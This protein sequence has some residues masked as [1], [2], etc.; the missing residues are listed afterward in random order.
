MIAFDY[1]GLRLKWALTCLVFYALPFLLISYGL[2]ARWNIQEEESIERAF[3]GLDAVLLALRKRED[4]GEYIQNQIM[5]LANQAGK[6]SDPFGILRRGFRELK[7]RFPGVLRVTICDGEGK[8][9]SEMTDGNPPRMVVRRFFETVTSGTIH[10]EVRERFASKVGLFKSFIGNEISPDHIDAMRQG[11]RRCSFYET[12]RYFLYDCR[13]GRFG[14]LVHATEVP[15]WGVLGMQDQ[16]RRF[17]TL[18]SGFGVEVGLHDIATR[19]TV[20]GP[21]AIALGAYQRTN[22]QH[23]QAADQLFTVMPFLTTARLWARRPRADALDLSRTRQAFTFAGIAVFALLTIFSHSVMVG[24]RPFPIS[25]RWRLVVLFGFASGLPLAVV[26]LAGWDYLN[27]KY[28]TRVRQSHD[29]MERLLL[30]FDARFP[31]MRGKLEVT[32]VRELKACR[33]DTEAQMR[34]TVRVL[35][36]FR[37]RFLA[38]DLI[39]YDSRGGVSWDAEKKTSIKGDRGRKMMGSIAG[40]ILANLNRESYQGKADAGVMFVESFTGG[41][42]PISHMT[43]NLGR[44]FD[45]T[46]AGASTWTFINPLM[47]RD[48]RSTH[49]VMA[50]WR[51]QALEQ[52]YLQRELITAQKA[53]P[54]VRLVSVGEKADDWTPAGFPYKTQL[55]RFHRDLAL[56]QSTTIGRVRAGNIRFLVTGVKPKEMGFQLLMAMLPDT[57]IKEEIATMQ[58]QLWLFTFLSAGISVF[59]GFIL[60]Q[61]FLTPIGHLSDGV[62]AIQKRAFQHR[63]PLGEPDEL[64]ELAATFNRV[65]EGLSDLEVGR[66]VQ[67]SLFPSQEVRA[68]SFRIFGTTTSAS[69][70]GGDYYDLQVLPD[71][72]MLVLIGDVSGHGVPAALVMAMAKALVEREC[73]IDATPDVLLANVHRVF[74]RTLKRRRM[75]TC[76]LGLLEPVTRVFSYANAGH[77]FPYLFRAGERAR[78]FENKALPLG[79]MKKNQF[80]TDRE[81]MQPGD[82]I[83]L[84]T[85]GLV[86]AKVRGGEAIGYTRMVDGVTPLLDDDPQASCRRI[87]TWHVGLTGG[88][89]QEDDITIVLVTCSGVAS[90]A[91]GAPA[92]S[93]P[94]TA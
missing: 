88:G 71:G 49:M 35:N 24:G 84:Y 28:N 56:R 60:S 26:I 72:R 27:Q 34:R 70:L 92:G 45:F 33:F 85:D 13:P 93:P 75:M 1:W 83:L 38:G 52:L 61:R 57:A 94:A 43:R 7:Q 12:D 65:M 16:C 76:F 63:V 89:P 53:M 32:F 22:R 39:M 36:R 81:T 78:F 42:S 21:L 2:D 77:N 5:T 59:L 50:N 69:E 23:I 48:G 9:L 74:Y 86:E 47:D 73:E 87:L 19:E 55:R 40:Q 37:E 8:M 25:I 44:V 66:I 82:R 62:T 51:K 11:F 54:G 46:L 15:G 20:V 29:E 4:T 79:S 18:R 6:A 14:I 91:S 58:R 31:Q 30:A 80:Q 64:G 67:E 10:R 3:G 90:P 17:N 41:E 68:G